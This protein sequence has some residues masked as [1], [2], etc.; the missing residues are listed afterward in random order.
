MFYVSSV[1]VEGFWEKYSARVDFYED[2]SILI[3]KN[4]TGKTTFMDMLQGS[5]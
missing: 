4:G 2:V 3:G 1:S 5:S